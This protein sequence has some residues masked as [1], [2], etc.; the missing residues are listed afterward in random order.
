MSGLGVS[1]L[2]RLPRVRLLLSLNQR[3]VAQ[4]LV[5]RLMADMGQ[6]NSPSSLGTDRLT[7]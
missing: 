1:P 3:G 6:F 7:S 2:E 4:R 5:H